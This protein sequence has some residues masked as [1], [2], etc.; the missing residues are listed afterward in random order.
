M[1]LSSAERT[2]VKKYLMHSL[3]WS[4]SI[5]HIGQALDSIDTD[6]N[7][8]LEVQAILTKIAKVETALDDQLDVMI[9]KK[10]DGTEL[11]L[12]EGMEATLDLGWRFVIQLGGMLGV[13]PL[14]NPF[15]D[16]PIS[17]DFLDPGGQIP[18]G[19]APRG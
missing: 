8:V 3:I 16:N 14:V 10:V 7:A 17:Y 18:F 19:V 2:K 12:R 11:S 9:A 6:A 1:P 4:D 5:M 13:R 15:G